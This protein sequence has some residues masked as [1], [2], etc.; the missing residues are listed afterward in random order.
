MNDSSAIRVFFALW[1]ERSVQYK[2]DALTREYQPKCNA[3]AMRA[4]TLHMTLLFIGAIAHTRLPQLMQAADGVLA[5][6]FEFTLETLA[7]WK[8]NK[9]AYAAPASEVP[10]LNHLVK[11]LRQALTTQDT[12]FTDTRFSPHVTLLR[13]VEHDMKP[14][15]I[16]P[17][18][19]RAS[20]FVLVASSTTS[21]GANYRILKEWP[22]LHPTTQNTQD[23]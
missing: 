11:S 13:H 3:R 1:P 18:T 7:F 9:I 5:P 10:A 17:I 15:N 23:N 22:L 21:V 16:A 20:T 2:L 8:H 12:P 19:W 14:Q 6:S 4:D